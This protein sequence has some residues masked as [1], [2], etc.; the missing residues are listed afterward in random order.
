MAPA[1]KTA[2]TETK[3]K[4]ARGPQKRVMHIFYKATTNDG[5]PV[6]S[7]VVVEIAN[8][9]SD[10][11]KVLEFVDSEAYRAAGLQRFKYELVSTPRGDGEEDHAGKPVVDGEQA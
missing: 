7:N 8:V 2:G 10:A 3:A 1:N 6:P 11:R 5:T 9:M 4:K